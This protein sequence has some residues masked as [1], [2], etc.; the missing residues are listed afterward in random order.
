MADG[1]TQLEVSENLKHR[2]IS[3]NSVST[4]EKEIKKLKKLF[5]AKSTIQLFV[6]LI[7]QGHLK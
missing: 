4:I 3:P 2:G 6:I 1:H 7:R 5:K